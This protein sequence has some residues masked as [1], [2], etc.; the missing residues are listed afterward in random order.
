MLGR[1]TESF[2]N[3]IHIQTHKH[4]HT[5]TYSCMFRISSQNSDEFLNEKFSTQIYW[6]QVLTCFSFLWLNIY[7]EYRD[8]IAL[9]FLWD[10][11]PWKNIGEDLY[12][13]L[14]L[15]FVRPTLCHIRFNFTVSDAPEMFSR[16]IPWT[17][18]I[19]CPH[20]VTVSCSN[21]KYSQTK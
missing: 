15:K 10:L 14:L 8:N 12:S 7:A 5:H 4:I 1:H 16:F 6:T 20:Q 9:T 11:A 18:Q 21:T 17:R 19:V 2:Y 3:G 13:F